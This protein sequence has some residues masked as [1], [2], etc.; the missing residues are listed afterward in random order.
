VTSAGSAEWR[1]TSRRAALKGAVLLGAGATVGLTTVRRAG[2]L[3]ADPFTL[4]VASGEPAP[5]G[6]VIWT[7]L[8]PRP[9][10][11]DGRGG[12]PDAVI[13]VEW[14]VAEDAGFAT[15]VQR[16]VTAARPEAAHSVHVELAGLRPGAEYFYRFRTAGFLSPPGRTRTAP[17][18]NSMPSQLT[19]CAVSCAN[20]ED[21]WFTA[22]RGVADEQPDLVVELGD[23]IYEDGRGRRGAPVV[24]RHVGAEPA[25]TL[26]DYRLRYAQ[27]RTDPDLQAAQAAAPWLVVFDDH[28]L[29]NNWADETPAIPQPDFAQRRA[30]ALQAY[31]ENM[32][33]RSSA[34]PVGTSMQLY[35]R[36]P[37]GGLAMFH[38]LDTRQYRTDQPCNDKLGSDCPERF[39]A[40]ASLTGVEQE[41]WLLDGFARSSSRWDLIA[42]QVLFAQLDLTP[43]PGRSVNPDAWDGYVAQRDRVV[44]ALADSPV[45]NAV[46]LTGDIHSHCAAEIWQ[47]F[48]DPFSRRVAVELVTTSI[49]SG[50]D[51]S[52]TKPEIA[53]ALPENPHI[54]YFSN[55]RG[56]LRAQLTPESLRADFRTLPYVSQPGAPVQTGASFIVPDGDPVLLN[57]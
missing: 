22:Y 9:L 17:Q 51:G 7:R 43:G 15:V 16:G 49:A 14:E 57:V 40:A 50:G 20:Y 4:G 33:L 5:D 56:Y 8:A 32:P 42:Q 35:R 31:Y 26:G 34:K 48:D 19:I 25:M 45:R 6:A 24:R 12:M 53:A 47:Q 11:D 28:E 23:F 3:P 27:Y 30:A 37:W 1:R 54:R 10:A 41:R 39:A 18:P 2:G 38:L 13:D 52:D 44:A 55:R 36:V 29:A 46:I 21:G